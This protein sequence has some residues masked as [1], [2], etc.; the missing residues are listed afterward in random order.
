MR[1]GI[2]LHVLRHAR[3]V[4]TVSPYMVDEVQPLCR[5]PVL[6]V[7]NPIATRASTRQRT[8]RAG[9][10]KVV[11]VGNGWG[12]RKNG[13]A[14]LQAFAMLAQRLPAAQLQLYG[15]DSEPGGAAQRCWQRLGAAGDVAFNG[16]VSHDHVLDAMAASDLMLHPAL[17]ESFGAVLAEAMAMG[18]P[19]VA[20]ERSGAVPWVVGNGGRLVDVTRPEPMAEAMQA[21]LIDPTAMDALG[22]LGRERVLANFSPAAVTARYEQQYEAACADSTRIEHA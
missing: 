12:P 5:T 15:Q 17:E 6:V 18:L 21:L 14:A 2:A 7:P 3:R 8:P 20:G 1:A 4:T 10:M 19:L 13:A 22:K 9:R 11:M 16:S